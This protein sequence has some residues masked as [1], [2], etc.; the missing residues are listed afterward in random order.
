VAALQRRAHQLGG[1]L[2]AMLGQC[3][4]RVDTGL[5]TQ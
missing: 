5:I 1:D 3:F 2:A 4:R